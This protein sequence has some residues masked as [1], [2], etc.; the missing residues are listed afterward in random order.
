MLSIEMHFASICFTL[1]S[2]WN[3]LCLLINVYFHAS[4]L[5]YDKCI[6]WIKMPYAFFVYCDFL[7]L[8]F[9]PLKCLMLSFALF[10]LQ[11]EINF[12]FFLFRLLDELCLV[13][14]PLNYGSRWLKLT[15]I[16]ARQWYCSQGGSHVIACL[17][18]L[19]IVLR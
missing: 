19:F 17:T 1:T 18:P 16:L 9:Y 2:I 12:A 7:N 11:S 8:K 6:C 15:R 5:I 13:F 10:W 14:I 3:P 4:I